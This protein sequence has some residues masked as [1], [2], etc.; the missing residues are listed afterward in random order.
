[1]TP[2]RIEPVLLYRPP[3][4][5]LPAGVPQGGLG[6]AGSQ[7]VSFSFNEDLKQLVLRVIDA[8]T[9]DVIKELPPE[10]QLRAAA[11]RREAIARFIDRKL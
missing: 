1:M 5:D 2:N 6:K 11:L 8:K 7:T 10:E 3:R 4:V 9:G